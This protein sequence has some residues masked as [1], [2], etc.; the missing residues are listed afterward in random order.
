MDTCDD[1]VG[2]LGSKLRRRSMPRNTKITGIAS[3]IAVMIF[4]LWFM[5][6]FMIYLP[7]IQT[8]RGIE[9][10]ARSFNPVSYVLWVLPCL[11]L[12]LSFPILASSI[13]MITNEQNKTWGL[14]GLVFAAMYGAILTTDYFVL[15][16]VIRD[17]ISSA[18]LDGLSWFIVGSPHSITNSIEGVGYTFMGLSFIF[19]G[20]CFD[21]SALGK[22]IAALLRINGTMTVIA[23]PLTIIGFAVGAWTSLGIWGI[24]FPVIMVLIILYFRKARCK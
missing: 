24:T 9:E 22:W 2:S 6:A 1:I 18:N 11:F 13:F 16:T 17:S 19:Q 20:F 15:L 5:I 3:A 14:I 8:W 7:E 4:T 12:A 21:Q 10:F 23:V